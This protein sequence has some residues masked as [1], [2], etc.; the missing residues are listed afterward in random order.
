MGRRERDLATFVRSG[1]PRVR[2]EFS[3]DDA[4]AMACEYCMAARRAG[5]D[6]VVDVDARGAFVYLVRR[7]AW[8]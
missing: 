6:G 5:L 1:L 2:I 8:G 7:E 4:V 3:V